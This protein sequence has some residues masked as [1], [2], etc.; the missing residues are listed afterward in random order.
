MRNNK[1]LFILKDTG[2]EGSNN[3]A[4]LLVDVINKFCNV[5]VTISY[6]NQ[7]KNLSFLSRLG[8]SV[9][10]NHYRVRKKEKIKSLIFT[11]KSFFSLIIF[12]SS[13][14]KRT[15]VVNNA[16]LIDV[17]LAS[18]I[19]RHRTFVFFRETHLPKIIILL[20]SF[21]ERNDLVTILSNNSSVVEKYDNLN[22]KIVSNVVTTSEDISLV[23]KNLSSIK[24]LA[25][26]A[27]YP[28]KNQL[29]LLKLIKS[30]S[31]NYDVSLNIYGR[32]VDSDYFEVLNKYVTDNDL[33]DNVFFKGE[34]ENIK[35]LELYCTHDFFIQSSLSEGMSRSM[36]DALLTGVYCIGS[37]VGD[38]AVLLSENRGFLISATPGDNDVKNIIEHVDYLYKNQYVYNQ[39]RFC[40]QEF[41]LE[42]YSIKTVLSQLSQSGVIQ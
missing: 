2:N 13:I 39:V 37:S 41:I 8:K 36:M 23:I 38:T 18:V 22:V 32:V 14:N 1:V 35:L 12:F 28:L 24:I 19:T 42:N 26:G 11:M 21:L 20:I 34:V 9:Y 40:S 17:I 30:L 25:V 3:S 10:L 6:L 15:V 31:L 29:F 4:K 7:A 27:I 16:M 33:V 5:P